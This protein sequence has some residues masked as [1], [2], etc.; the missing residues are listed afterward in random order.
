MPFSHETLHFHLSLK[1]QYLKPRMHATIK[2]MVKGGKFTNKDLALKKFK[3]YFYDVAHVSTYAPYCDALVMDQVMVDLVCQS[4]VDLERQYSTK[5][6]GLKNW[7]EFLDWLDSQ[8][9]SVT[10]AHK[11]ALAAAYP[12]MNL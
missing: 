7:D 4:T 11:A 6:F 2:S 3:C 10:D 8:S 12:T 5:V 1:R 9:E